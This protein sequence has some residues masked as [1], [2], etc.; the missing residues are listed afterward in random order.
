M[1]VLL[2]LCKYLPNFCQISWNIMFIF[3]LILMVPFLKL[4][5]YFLLFSQKLFKLVLVTYIL[6]IGCK[7]CKKKT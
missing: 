2:F 6:Y 4:K 1:Y 7:Y 3:N 5:N